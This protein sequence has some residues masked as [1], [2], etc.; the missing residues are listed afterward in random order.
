MHEM[1][2]CKKL[3]QTLEQQARVQDF[4]RVKKVWLTLGSGAGVTADGLRFNFTMAAQ[5]SLAE[6]AELIIAEAAPDPEVQ[7]PA[8]SADVLRILELE[9]I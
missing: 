9:V 1:S 6:G 8:I 3:L 7:P 5:G 4:Q 2:L